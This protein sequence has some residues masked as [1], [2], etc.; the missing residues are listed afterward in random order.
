MPCVPCLRCRS[1]ADR[2][3][4]SRARQSRGF[5]GSIVQ[6]TRVDGM[7][8]IGTTA[9]PAEE[10]DSVQV[11]T[12][13]AG[14]IYGPAAP[15][16]VFDYTFKRPT[17]QTLARAIVDYDSSSIVTEQADLGGRVGKDGWLGYR[18]NMLQGSGDGIVDGSSLS[19]VMI[20]ADF[21][22]HVSDS[23]VIELDQSH[24]YLDQTGYSGQFSFA[25]GLTSTAPANTHPGGAGFQ[26]RGLRPARR[27]PAPDHRSRLGAYSARFRQWL[28]PHPGRPVRG[29]QSRLADRQQQPDQQCRQFHGAEEF[30]RCRAVHRRQQHRVAQRHPA[31]P[32]LRQ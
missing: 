1:K 32:G 26:Y 28:A 9:Y 17:D 13:L 12:G 31:H 27:R 10:L 16:G 5:E 14:A 30:Q 7:N 22:I 15:S 11:L 4:T 29:G 25:G 8:V 21:D 23:T 2:A 18:L 6:N 24:S 19:R 3:W 20:N